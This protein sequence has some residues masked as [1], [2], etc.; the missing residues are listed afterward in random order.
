MSADKRQR[1]E[2]FHLVGWVLFIICAILF[3]LSGIQNDDLLTTVGS[4]IFLIACVVFLI[5]LIHP[6]ENH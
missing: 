2:K 4:F 6:K 1:E 3:I 5:P